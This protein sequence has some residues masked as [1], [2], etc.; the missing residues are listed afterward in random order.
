MIGTSKLLCSP[1]DTVFESVAEQR[2]ISYEFSH[3]PSH[4]KCFASAYSSFLI[5]NP[6]VGRAV[7]RIMLEDNKFTETMKG[8]VQHKLGNTP[9]ESASGALLKEALSCAF[10][11]GERDLTPQIPQGTQY[12]ASQYTTICG[13]NQTS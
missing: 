11:P 1:C 8:R 3:P 10:H 13:T 2:N 7:L 12:A 6:E 9:L 5:K 4:G